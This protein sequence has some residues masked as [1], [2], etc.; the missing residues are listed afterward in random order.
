MWWGN[1]LRL[2]RHPGN[3]SISLRGAL[4]RTARRPR[5]RMPQESALESLPS[6]SKTA[7]SRTNP[8]PEYK[9]VRR[10]KPTGARDDNHASEC[11]PVLIKQPAFPNAKDIMLINGVDPDCKT[12]MFPMTGVCCTLT[13]NKFPGT[14]F[15]STD[16]PLPFLYSDNFG[17]PAAPKPAP[18]KPQPAPRPETVPGPSSSTRDA[19]ERKRPKLDSGQTVEVELAVQPERKR[20]KREAERRAEA[21]AKWG[22][23]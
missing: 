13:L 10:I 19:H 5:T 17:V 18:L 16:F 21:L 1:G 2:K 15:K 20:P 7:F 23:Q 22:K 8:Q 14:K 11:R 6:F 4:G 3:L 12:S 9:N